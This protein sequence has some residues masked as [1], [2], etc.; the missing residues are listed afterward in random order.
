MKKFCFLLIVALMATTSLFAE[1]ISIDQALQIARKFSTYPSTKKL[2]KSRASMTEVT[3][4]LA[5][6]VRSKVA[7]E[8]DNVYIVNLG[9]DQGFVIVSG[10]HNTDANVLGYCDHGTFNYSQAPLQ[11]KDLLNSYSAIIDSLRLMPVK[12]TR[13]SQNVNEELGTVMVGPLLTTTWDQW[14]PFNN[15]C[16][17]GCPTGCYPTAIAQVMNYWKWPKQSIGKVDGQDFSGHVYDWDNMLDDYSGNYSFVQAN[18]VAQ[19][20]ADIGKAFHTEYH[21]EGSPTSFVSHPLRLNFGYNSDYEFGIVEHSA[22]LASDLQDVIKADLKKSCPVLFCGSGVGD[23]HALVCDGYTNKDYFHFNY[24]WGG[25]CDGYY[26]NALCGYSAN[27]TLFT[28]LRPFNPDVKTIGDLKYEV[29]K[30]TGTAEIIE[31]DK[32]GEAGDVLDIPSTVTDDEGNTYKVT[33]IRQMAF[34]RKG[35]F[36]KVIVGENLQKVD[37]YSFMYTTIDTLI[38]SDKM[39]EIPDNAFG[40]SKVRSLTIGASVKRIGKRAFQYCRTSEIICKSPSLVVDD[41]AFIDARIGI[42]GG[43]WVGHV[44]RVGKK[45]FWGVRFNENPLFTQLEEID[46]LAFGYAVFAP[47]GTGELSGMGTFNIMAKVK[48]IVPNAFEC[49]NAQL[50][51]VDEANPYFTNHG[52]S[53]VMNKNKTSLVLI[54]NISE[55]IGL[56]EGYFPEA[57]I[58][59]EPGCISSRTSRY[60]NGV[61]IP[62]TVVEMEGAFSLCEHLG[63]LRCPS[64]VP[65][66]ITDSTF[67]DQIF[68]NNPDI[69]LYVPEGTEELYA[70]APGWRRFTEIIGE[71]EY[72]PMPKQGIEYDMVV[73]RTGENLQ[74]VRIPVKEIADLQMSNSTIPGQ[75]SLVVKRTGKEDL[76]TRIENVDSITWTSSYVYEDAELFNLND[77]TLTAEAQKCKVTL[78]PTVIDGDAQM[79]IR[80]VVLT[81]KVVEGIVRGQAVDVTLL[82]NT[83]EVHELSGVAEIAIPIKRSAD[84][85][86]QAAYFNEE[87]QEWE[88][89]DFRYDEEKGAVVITTDHLSL[90]DAFVVKNEDKKTA[91]LSMLFDDCRLFFDLTGSLATMYHVISSDDPDE[92]AVQAFRDDYGFWQSVGIDG[93]WN[94]L[95]AMGFEAEH[96][97]KAIDVVGYLGIAATVFDVAAADLKGDDIGVASNTLKS[98][99]AFSTG[100]MASAIGTGIMSA[101]MISAAF[102]SVA[103]EKFGTKVMDRKR[104][105]YRVAYRLYYSKEGRKIINKDSSFGEKYYRT[106]KDWYDYFY[107]YFLKN[108]TE[109]QMRSYIE[110]SVRRYCDRFWED[111]GSAPDWCIEEAKTQGLTSYMY[112]DAATQ[113]AISD[114]Y[115]AELMNGDLV[116]VFQAIK[117]NMEV[118][119]AKRYKK[120]VKDYMDMVNTNV[121]LRIKDSSWKKGEKSKYA[122]W[123]IRFSDIPESV[124]DASKWQSIIDDEGKANI[125]YLTEYALIKNKTRLEL[126]L[127]NAEDV[128][129]RTFSFTIPEGSGKVMVDIDLATGG[130]EIEAPRLKNLTLSY[131]PSTIEGILFLAGKNNFGMNDEIDY[132]TTIYL[133]NTLNNVL[134]KSRFQTEIEKFF[135]RHDFIV[136][137]PSGNIRIGDDIIGKFEGNEGKG[138]FTIKTSY[139]FEEK[140]IDQY[141]DIINSGD[142]LSVFLALH[143]LISGTM[144]HEIDCGFTVTRD[145]NGEGYDVRFEGSGTFKFRAEVVDRI[146][147]LDLTQIPDGVHNV[148]K[149]EISTTQKEVEGKVTLT[150]TTKLH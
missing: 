145:A 10:E 75:S 102:I 37:P 62:N 129:Q 140:T 72:T 34:F 104:E 35:T 138:R 142:N 13:A 18:A 116:S 65:P 52:W 94:T 121:C 108:R 48:K 79:S 56:G 6:A 20:M 17:E 127:V 130:I 150:Y 61:T 137:D 27:A 81:P 55:P 1:D 125:G 139:P 25:Y 90:F 8:K 100:Q 43:E 29:V 71:E 136:V 68:E 132:E 133:D 84:E 103:L 119:A 40:F 105:L 111:T 16:P 85:K 59:M 22:T 101:S 95:Q 50:L 128:D 32:Y 63:Y 2:S 45:A 36:D 123:K 23:P 67:N 21:P 53:L 12:A 107:P 66:E 109:E 117:A 113:K 89:V 78:G 14:G 49:S 44:T 24:G 87:T 74:D 47:P 82:T 144:E 70:N 77:S 131:D 141:R 51:K 19:L 30:E 41:E 73:H 3:P 120:A 92:E 135:K 58:K 98:I 11:M 64:I 9:N 86:A 143:S 57:M 7:T 28:G 91:S 148:L 42:D 147:N 83:G 149:S 110:Q 114:E 122:G 112:P 88:P 69:T 96:I 38:I 4:T 80:N 15:L 39:E 97:S 60:S 54:S 46:S 134:Y 26:K 5:Y 146:K 33:S 115:F 93:G 124:S 126:T 31:C 99:M 106:K 76:T 118:Q